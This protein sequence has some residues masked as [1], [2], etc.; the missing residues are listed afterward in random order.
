MCFRAGRGNGYLLAVGN[1]EDGNGK[2]LAASRL[3]NL[4]P[5]LTISLDG[6]SVSSACGS[7]PSRCRE[8]TVETSEIGNSTSR[9][10]VLIPL[11]NGVQLL[12]LVHNGTSNQLNLVTQYALVSSGISGNRSCGPTLSTHKIGSEY[13][14]S[15]ISEDR[16]YS[17][18]KLT[19]NSTIISQSVLQPCRQVVL[20]DGTSLSSISNFAIANESF[21]FLLQNVLHEVHPRVRTD[22]PFTYLFPTYCSSAN[23]LL[24]SPEDET[25]LLV[26]C[27]NHNVIT[28]NLDLHIIERI[29]EQENIQ[30]PCSPR[31]EYIVHL[32]QTQ[33]DFSYKLDDG[34]VVVKIFESPSASA[35]FH[36]GV[37]FESAGSHLF[38]YNDMRTGV[39]LFNATS[40]IFRLLPNTQGCSGSECE[41]PLVFNNRYII[42]RNR[43]R[44]NVTV[45]D[46]L[47]NNSII[48]LQNTPLQ[49]VSII[50]DLPFALQMAMLS[51]TT[52]NNDKEPTGSSTPNQGQDSMKRGVPIE[53]VVPVVVIVIVILLITVIVIFVVA[54]K[55]W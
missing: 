12:E 1:D 30:Y 45:F 17:V 49:L 40:E 41:L 14:I 15:C 26:Y 37:C 5:E 46:M 4:V 35:D 31:A 55:K 39:Y 44:R 6:H 29:E 22:P 18:C 20:S 21:L 48:N 3:A 11:E 34:T 28:Y 38:T 42:V 27:H 7:H 10:I 24:I 2:L 53:V 33:M 13:F 8:L 16:L 32:S 54:I 43:E 47:T 9:Y 19:L 36:S 23:Q 25:K 51:V 52:P 50:Y